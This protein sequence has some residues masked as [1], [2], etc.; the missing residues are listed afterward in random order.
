MEHGTILAVD[1]KKNQ[2]IKEQLNAKFPDYPDHSVKS[3]FNGSGLPTITPPSRP[4]HHVSRPRRR[5]C[6]QLRNNGALSSLPQHHNPITFT[7]R[8][9]VRRIRPLPVH[10]YFTQLPRTRPQLPYLHQSLQRHRNGFTP[11][12]I[13]NRYVSTETKRWIIG[14]VK[15]GVRYTLYIWAGGFLL[16]LVA[17]GV[18]QEKMERAFPSPPQYSFISRYLYRST[19]VK[20]AEEFREA[21]AT[22]FALTSQ[23]YSRLLARLEDPHID[24]AGLKS[25]GD[26]G[27][28]ISVD[29]VGEMG[30]DITSKP[31]PWRRGYYEVLL[32]CARAAEFLDSCVKDEKRTLAFPKAVVIGPSNPNPKPMPPGSPPAPREEDCVPA[33]DPPEKFYMKILTTNGF[34]EGQK[35]DAALALGNWLSYKNTPQAAEE[36]FRWALDIA[37]SST[38]K[39]NEIYDPRTYIIKPTAPAP[40]ANILKSV[41]ALAEHKAR[42]GDLNSALPVM[43]S[44]LRARKA[45]PSAPPP[46]PPN[47]SSGP[48]ETIVKGALYWLIAPEFPEPPPSGQEVPQRDAKE[49]CEEGALMAYMGEIL[50]ATANNQAGREDGLG[51]TREAVD[52]AEEELRGRYISQD[53]RKT[54][55]QCLSTGLGNWRAMVSTLAKE[56]R[57]RKKQGLPL[58]APATT[59]GWFGFGASSETPEQA[60][61]RVQEQE[62]GRWIMEE[63]LV[64]EKERQAR[65]FLDDQKAKTGLFI[66]R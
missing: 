35:V 65:Q 27:A 18:E 37:S 60:G 19:R 26:D 17:L 22:D 41:T 55:K 43:L 53:A 28:P 45:L 49:R 20:D 14:D 44:L 13:L 54:C 1:E 7:M 40:S 38:P 8:P 46:S 4:E 62:R 2:Y 66:F 33:F 59:S 10:R 56:E 47:P 29:G 23:E 30:Y 21:G 15:L 50:Y 11:N 42:N 52:V 25:Q 58:E 24:G 61:K 9:L 63:D 31:E 12:S 39:A 51:W 3:V 57:Q 36:M 16:L 64:L 5:G 32:G 48:M 34:T 6:A